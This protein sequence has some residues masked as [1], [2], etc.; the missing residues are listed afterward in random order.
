MDVWRKY[1]LVAIIHD[2]FTRNCSGASAVV[3]RS[4]A[5]ADKREVQR[6]ACLT[7]FRFPWWNLD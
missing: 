4:V 6:I 1:K 3:A 2:G 5:L 7:Y